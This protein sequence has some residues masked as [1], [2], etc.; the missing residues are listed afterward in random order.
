MTS[1]DDEQDWDD[2]DYGYDEYGDDTE[3]DQFPCPDCGKPIYE[4][5]DVCPQC[6]YFILD[7]DRTVEVT[8]QQKLFRVLGLIG[9]VITMIV[10]SGLVH[11]AVN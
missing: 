3:L 9:I 6:G 7:S 4:D 2:P 11:F 1:Y 5:L 10:L 8:Q